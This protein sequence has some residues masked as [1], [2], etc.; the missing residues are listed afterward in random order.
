M[1]TSTT[2]GEIR[3][4]SILGQGKDFTRENRILV[5]SCW[6]TFDCEI[7]YLF[8]GGMGRHSRKEKKKPSVTKITEMRNN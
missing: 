3:Y 5:H 6:I 1:K 7:F 8:Q 4:N 2:E